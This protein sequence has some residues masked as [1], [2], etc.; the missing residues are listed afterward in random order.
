MEKYIKHIICKK[1]DIS[2]GFFADKLR[3]DGH[4]FDKSI[5]FLITIMAGNQEVLAESLK[6]QF[7][8]KILQGQKFFIIYNAVRYPFSNERYGT[9]SFLE[10]KRGDYEK[11]EE[12]FSVL[13]KSLRELEEKNF[14]WV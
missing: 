13:K 7:K 6:K 4:N 8:E 5:D 14:Y 2:K 12:I 1:V 9:Y 3:D 11:I 10:M